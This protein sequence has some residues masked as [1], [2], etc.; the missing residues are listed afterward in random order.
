MLKAGNQAGELTRAISEIPLVPISIK[1]GVKDRNRRGVHSQWTSRGVARVRLKAQCPK[2][3]R[4]GQSWIK[5]GRA[6]RLR[7][8]AVLEANSSEPRRGRMADPPG[9]NPAGTKSNRPKSGIDN[10]IANGHASKHADRLILAMPAM[11]ETMAR[12]PAYSY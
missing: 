12:A 1:S 8:S 7:P 11:A 6:E 10:R 4:L 9:F 2:F 3:D 5:D